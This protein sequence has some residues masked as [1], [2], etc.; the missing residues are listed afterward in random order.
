M[1]VVDCSK[2]AITGYIPLGQRQNFHIGAMTFDN[3]LVLDTEN[4]RILSGNRAFSNISVVE[5]GY[6]TLWLRNGWNWISF[7]RLERY[8]NDYAPS[9]P[10][11][12]RISCFPVELTLYDVIDQ[13][14][15][16]D[17]ELNEWH[18]DLDI[19]RSTDGYKLYFSCNDMQP[20]LL[21]TGSQVDPSTPITLYPNKANWIGYFIEEAQYPWHAFPYDLFHG[22]GAGTLVRIQARTWAMSKIIKERGA[23]WLIAHPTKI[24]PIE[25]GDMVKV[26]IRGETPVTFTWNNPAQGDQEREA[27]KTVFYSYTEQIDYLPVFIETSPESDYQEIAVL[28]GGQVKGASVRLPG[29]TIVQINAYIQNVPPGTPLEIE[30]WSGLKSNHASLRDYWVLNQQ[31]GIFENRKVYADES[32]SFQ[33]LSLK[34]HSKSTLPMVLGEVTCHPNPF[35]QQTLFNFWLNAESNIRLSIYDL[36]GNRV[37]MLL[38]GTFPAGNHQVTWDGTGCS[39]NRLTHGVYL[40]RLVAGDGRVTSGRII[41]MP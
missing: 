39:G 11:L 38:N 2:D 34:K 37:A 31:K 40:Y 18:G 12:E 9:V 30:T 22:T 27:L 17:F 5:G 15:H 24:T 36:L 26:W 21:M 7:P 1:K 33:F 41:L 13:T 20:H 28:A 16:F 14:K 32:T 10:V 29:D 4:N 8:G 19:V 25:Y 6:D 23:V 3:P 35:S